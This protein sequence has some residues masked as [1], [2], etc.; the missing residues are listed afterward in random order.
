MY[1]VAM[2]TSERCLWVFYFGNTKAYLERNVTF[3]NAKEPKK[4]KSK[5]KEKKNQRDP[6]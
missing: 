1:K 3:R 5:K 4:K 6:M 2:S